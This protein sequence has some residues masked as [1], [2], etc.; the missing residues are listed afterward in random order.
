MQVLIGRSWNSVPR[1]SAPPI[2]P[3]PS[4]HATLLKGAPRGNRLKGKLT[5]AP[6]APYPTPITKRGD[7]VD[8][9]KTFHYSLAVFFFFVCLFFNPGTGWPTVGGDFSLAILRCDFSID[10]H[11]SCTQRA[12]TARGA[13]WLF[14]VIHLQDEMAS[15]RSG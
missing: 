14:R 7:Q 13:C 5:P 8:R 1:A 15:P 2:S 10:T 4:K 12:G 3:F 11:L 6:P 9:G